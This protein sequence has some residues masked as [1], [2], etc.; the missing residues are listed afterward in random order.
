[1]TV[2]SEVDGCPCGDR[3]LMTPGGLAALEQVTAGLDPLVT[4][5]MPG[6]AWR[7][8]RLYIACHGLKA[9]DLPQL[10][11]VYGWERVDGPPDHQAA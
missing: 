9:A 1:M 2:L 7:V 11:A 6:G 5:G 10:A 8:P 4:V 3:H